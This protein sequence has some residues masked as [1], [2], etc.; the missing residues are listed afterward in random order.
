MV[1]F[2]FMKK[3]TLNFFLFIGLCISLSNVTAE[4]DKS[5]PGIES[6]KAYPRLTEG[7][8]YIDG[9]DDAARIVLVNSKG[10]EREL[11]QKFF[12]GFKAVD[13]TDAIPGTYQLKIYQDDIVYTEIIVKD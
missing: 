6:I 13:F 2:W 11:K 10:E 5:K 1:Y 7:I 3:L 8:V 9:I 12:R 4:D